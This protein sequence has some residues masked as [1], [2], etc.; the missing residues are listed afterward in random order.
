M[1]LHITTIAFMASLGITVNALPIAISE[2]DVVTTSTNNAKRLP[3][4]EAAALEDVNSKRDEN[5][6]GDEDIEE[7]DSA[8]LIVA[9]AFK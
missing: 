9:C 7:D 4:P 8:G 1:H 2:P 5:A 3:C 6:E